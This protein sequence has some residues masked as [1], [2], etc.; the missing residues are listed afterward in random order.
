MIGVNRDY[1]C[2][3]G[4]VEIFCMSKSLFFYTFFFL[5]FLFLVQSAFSVDLILTPRMLREIKIMENRHF[6]KNYFELKEK[7]RINNLEEELFGVNFE[8][9]P[10][11]KRMTQGTSIPTSVGISARRIQNDNIKIVDKNDVGIIDG[12]MKLY[13]PDAY[14]VWKRQKEAEM[15]YK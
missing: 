13:A 14:E 10:I 11:E 5:F 7:I 4:V 15:Q 9:V 1:I 3:L 2:F 8:G 12:L 6:G